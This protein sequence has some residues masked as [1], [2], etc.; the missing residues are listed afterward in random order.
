MARSCEFRELLEQ[1]VVTG[2]RLTTPIM[3]HM[4]EANWAGLYEARVAGLKK[5]KEEGKGEGRSPPRDE[6]D[7]ENYPV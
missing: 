1:S 7:C 5:R 4:C 6:E 2:P 3:R